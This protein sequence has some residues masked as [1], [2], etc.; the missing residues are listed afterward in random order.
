MPKSFWGEA[1]STASHLVNR[2][3]ST[4][5]NFKCPE[6]IWT[7]K[8]LNF[9][10]LRVFS[11][12]VYAHQSKGKL[13]PKS[14]KCVFVGYQEG[15][16]GYRLWDRHSGGVKIIISRDVIFNEAKFPCK[17]TNIAEPNEGRK[18]DDH[19]ILRDTQIQVE[20]PAGGNDLPVALAT[21]EPN[22]EGVTSPTDQTSYHNTDHEEQTD[23]PKIEEEQPNTPQQDLNDY[24]LA[25]DKSRR[26]VRPPF[27]YAYLDL[28]YCALV[29]GNELRDSKP[30]TYEEVVNSQD[31]DKWQ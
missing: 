4:I 8:K 2:S 24:Q 1:L 6:E 31:S 18:L 21:L 13:E 5:L 17:L 7:G 16:E 11:C 20:Q 3:P 9:N 12:E 15:T 10:Y 28:V 29:A 22:M 14:K 30:S 26:V 19:V 27:R 23:D 25:R